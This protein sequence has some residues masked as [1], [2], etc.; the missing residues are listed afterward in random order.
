MSLLA[1]ILEATASGASVSR[2]VMGI[3][4]MRS[5]GRARLFAREAKLPERSQDDELA[6]TWA[7]PL[8]RIA[9]DEHLEAL[10]DYA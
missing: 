8:E 5:R 1:R 6:T 9:R 7:E 4:G 2:Q 10:G 3:E